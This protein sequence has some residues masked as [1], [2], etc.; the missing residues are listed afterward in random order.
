VN[1]ENLEKEKKRVLQKIIAFELDNEEFHD[2]I[3]KFVD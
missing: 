1:S 2:M 3:M